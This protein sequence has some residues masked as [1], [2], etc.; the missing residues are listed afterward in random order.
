MSAIKHDLGTA[1]VFDCDDYA[2][3]FKA[4]IGYAAR[5]NSQMTGG[6]PIAS[7]IVW[8]VCSWM[9]PEQH[10][11]NWFVLDN[12]RIV[13]IEPQY[14]NAHFRGRGVSAVRPQSD[15][16]RDVRMILF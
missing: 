2:L 8:A 6:F 4:K 5:K 13:W 16:V 9:G 11:A 1:E 15:T 3:T 12:Q 14:N 10:A 7:G